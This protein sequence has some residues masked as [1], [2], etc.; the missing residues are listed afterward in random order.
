M[1]FRAGPT[2]LNELGRESYE[3]ACR[4][5][6]Y[7]EP[8]SDLERLCLVHSEISEAVECARTDQPLIWFDGKKPEGM[9]AELADAVIRICDFAYARGIDLDS[10]IRAKSDY[11][12]TRPYKHGKK[13]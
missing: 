9:A 12:E 1:S 10:A 8:P 11:N 4:K 5:G 6:F 7:E 2:N 13:L 3:R